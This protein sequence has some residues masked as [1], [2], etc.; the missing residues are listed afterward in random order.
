MPISPDSPVWPQALEWANQAI[1]HSEGKRLEY[2]ALGLWTRAHAYRALGRRHEAIANLKQALE[3]AR[4]LSDP[5]MFVRVASLLLELDGD[6]PL[7]RDAAAAVKQI[8]AELPEAGMRRQF[9]EAEPVRR[10]QRFVR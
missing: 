9:T 6:D 8:L 4:T 3:I 1:R 5:A 2:H 7:A 10:I